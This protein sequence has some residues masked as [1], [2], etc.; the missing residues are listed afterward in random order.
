M[1]TVPLTE[2]FRL[3]VRGEAFNA[4]NHVNFGPVSANIETPATFGKIL[5]RSDPRLLQVG[6]RLEF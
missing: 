4:F 6:M 1:E 2:R 3:Q 5:T